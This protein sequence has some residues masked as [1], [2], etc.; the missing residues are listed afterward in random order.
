MFSGP[1]RSADEEIIRLVTQSS[2]ARSIL[3]VTSDREIIRSIKAKGAQQIGSAAFLQALVDDHA[4]P[5]KKQVRRPSGLSPERAEEWK[6]EFGIDEEVLKDLHNTP[7]P[8]FQKE[9]DPVAKPTKSAVPQEKT[10]R[11][12]KPD[13]PMLP[14]DLLQEA[15]QL[16]RRGLSS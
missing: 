16:I 8:N 2:S 3:V 14:D 1:N 12:I 5:K 9:K 4:T 13:E 11:T 7:M 15:R 10:K 6:Q